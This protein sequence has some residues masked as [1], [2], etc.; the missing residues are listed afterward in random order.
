M[1]SFNGYTIGF[2]HSGDC[3]GVENNEPY[4]A[5]VMNRGTGC[6][7]SLPVWPG[8]GFNGFATEEEV[9]EGFCWI[10]H[11]ALLG[12]LSLADYAYQVSDVPIYRLNYV[13]PEWRR[14][15]N[16]CREAHNKMLRVFGSD[17]AIQKTYNALASREVV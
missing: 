16:A 6:Q 15:W 13:A 11:Q 17:A 2:S 5:T 8:P 4:T 9:L 7:E 1:V 12:K 14:G 3:P 10:L